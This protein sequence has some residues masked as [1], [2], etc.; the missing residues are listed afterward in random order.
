MKLRLGPMLGLEWLRTAAIVIAGI[1]LLRRIHKGQ[2][3]RS[4]SAGY[5]SKIEVR[6]P[7]GMRYWQRNKKGTFR[8]RSDPQFK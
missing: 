8:V 6:L 2:F 1:E 5:A 7:F 3:N 4:T